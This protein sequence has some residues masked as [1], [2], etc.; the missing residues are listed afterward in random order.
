MK[1]IAQTNP[2][3]YRH[4]GRFLVEMSQEEIR[5]VG[6]VDWKKADDLIRPGFESDPVALLRMLDRVRSST[7]SAGRIADN[8]RSLGDLVEGVVKE[9]TRATEPRTGGTV[10]VQP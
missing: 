4:D 5:I 3:S 7:E 9:A 10:E 6:G 1:V 8:L 2:G